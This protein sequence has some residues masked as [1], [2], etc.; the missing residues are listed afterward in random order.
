MS[1]ASGQPQ[2]DPLGALSPELAEACRHWAGIPPGEVREGPDPAERQRLRQLGAACHQSMLTL[3]GERRAE[4]I[5]LALGGARLFGWLLATDSEEPDW[6]AVME[7]QFCRYGALWI[8]EQGEADPHLSAQALPLI[9]R[10]LE[11]HPTQQEWIA[12]TRQQLEAAAVIPRGFLAPTLTAAPFPWPEPL[13]THRLSHHPASNAVVL[14]IGA[15]ADGQWFCDS[16]QYLPPGWPDA[17]WM[18]RVAGYRLE[19][20]GDG[21]GLRPLPDPPPV[22]EPQAGTWCLLNDIVG[23]RNLAHFFSDSLPQL[24]AM[25]RLSSE[26]GPLTLLA[27]RETHANLGHLRRLLWPG[28]VRFRGDLPGAFRVERLV[29]QP[30][31]F[32]G[33]SGFHP[34]PRREWFF[35]I[36]DYREGLEL[37]RGALQ[38]PSAEVALQDHWICFSRDLAAPTEAPQGRHFSNYPDLL[39]RLSNH[40]VLILDPGRHDIRALNGLIGRARGFV[41]IHGAGLANAFLAS[42]GARMIEIR[43]QGGAWL[44]LELLGRAAGLD[45]QVVDSSADPGDPGRSVIPI[46]AVLDR[47]A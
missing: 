25:R 37:L 41:G 32:N 5:A 18:Q 16:L 8:H 22:L 39:E 27:S 36:D 43:P 15:I 33:G 40:G 30:V 35:A 44:M 20:R 45:W 19:R 26:L 23:H 28:E 29:L 4:A 13:H 3:P 12:A 14:P 42:Q 47:L 10:L 1:A 17:P 34:H 24:A 11:L 9:D 2:P 21:I 6:V 7:E 31:A 46:Q 38:Q